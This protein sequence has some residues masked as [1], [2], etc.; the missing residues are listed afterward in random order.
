SAS[1]AKSLSAK[2]ANPLSA[3]NH[4]LP[5]PKSRFLRQTALCKACKPASRAKSRVTLSKIPHKFA[6]IP[7][8]RCKRRDFRGFA[9]EICCKSVN[10]TKPNFYY[11]TNP[12]KNQP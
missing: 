11:N 9:A 12:E 3:P 10:S 1:R 7:A 4:A 6:K 8:K 5:Y 2:P